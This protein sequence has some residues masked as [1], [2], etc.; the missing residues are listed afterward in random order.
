MKKGETKVAEK[1]EK[2]KKLAHEKAILNLTPE[3]RKRLEAR[4]IEGVPRKKKK[5]NDSFGK[6]F[7]N[8]KSKGLKTFTWNGNQYS[9]KT[10]DD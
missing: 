10:K 6:A 7:R 5:K 4:G 8:A 3:Q 1:A 9:T 2:I